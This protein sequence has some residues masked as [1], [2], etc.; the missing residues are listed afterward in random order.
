MHGSSAA[1]M[2]RAWRDS[3]ESCMPGTVWRSAPFGTSASAA[4]KGCDANGTNAAIV[5][6]A[7]TAGARPPARE[8]RSTMLRLRQRGVDELPEPPLADSPWKIMA[9]KHAAQA[10]LASDV[11]ELRK[12]G[13]PNDVVRIGPTVTQVAGFG[14]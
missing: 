1:A 3:V 7:V 5:L 2:R 9:L 10:P 11:L 14:P 4:L 6:R 8:P 12:P 13:A